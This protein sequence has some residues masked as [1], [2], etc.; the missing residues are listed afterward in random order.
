MHPWLAEDW[1]TYCKSRKF[2]MHVIF[3]YFVRGGFRTKIKC[4]RKVQS[5]LENPQ[6][7]ATVRTFHAYERSESRGL[8]SAYEIFWIYSTWVGTEQ[9]VAKLI[10]FVHIWLIVQTCN[11]LLTSSSLTSKSCPSNRMASTFSAR[12][13]L[14]LEGSLFASAGKCTCAVAPWKSMQTRQSLAHP[15]SKLSCY[16]WQDNVPAT[17]L[18]ASVKQY[19]CRNL[20]SKWAACHSNVRV[21]RVYDNNSRSGRSSV[22]CMQEKARVSLFSVAFNLRNSHRRHCLTNGACQD[23]AAVATAK[24]KLAIVQLFGIPW[25]GP[26]GEEKNQSWFNA[27]LL[28]ETARNFFQFGSRWS[29]WL[30]LTRSMPAA[31]LRSHSDDLMLSGRYLS[32][33]KSTRPPLINPCVAYR[34]TWSAR[35]ENV[36]PLGRGV[37]STAIPSSINAANGWHIFHGLRPRLHQ[38]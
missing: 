19:L 20:S 10:N 26:L 6:W 36:S 12:S 34:N 1:M 16:R 13:I 18:C 29:G 28:S 7:S 30:I 5:K 14:I 11:K 21:R 33:T 31:A 35:C 3:V 23:I 32:T 24:I 15:I 25:W 2:H 8:L 37:W 17:L 22:L 38:M 9:L 27:I 4:V